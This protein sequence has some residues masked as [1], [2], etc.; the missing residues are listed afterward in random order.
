MIP[1]VL[2]LGFVALL[3]FTAVCS[4]TAWRWGQT[5]GRADAR[6]DEAL[7]HAEHYR[8]RAKAAEQPQ[9]ELVQPLVASEPLR[10]PSGATEVLP[11]VRVP[12]YREG[13]VT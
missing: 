5:A 13:D 9:Q 4:A 7:D 2:L 1:V 11:A 3:V 8:R 10:R 12:D 6:C